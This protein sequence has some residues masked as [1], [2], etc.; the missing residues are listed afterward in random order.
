MVFGTTE[1]GLATINFYSREWYRGTTRGFEL[2][3]LDFLW[4]FILVDEWRRPRLA[5][6]RQLPFSL[7]SM[8]V[9][10]SYNAMNVALSD[11]KLF[12]LFEL[13]KALRAVMVFLAFA[14]YVKNERDLRRLVWA[15]CLAVIYEWSWTVYARLIL[16][17][18][19]SEGT[20]SH[21]NALSMYNLIAV[22]L[23][24]A[25]AL[26]DADKRLRRAC[27]VA[28]F[29]GTTS[30]LFTV[31]RAGLLSI[32]LLLIAVGMTCGSLRITLA[33]TVAAALVLVPGGVLYAKLAPAFEAR[34]A[35]E[36]GLEREFGGE[37]NEGRGSY[38]VLARMMS[39]D[40]FLGCGLNNWS[41]Y[42]SNRYG[43]MMGLQYLPYW[44]TDEVPPDGPIPANSN[45]D[46]PQAPPGHSLYAITLGETGWLGVLLF[47][48]VWLRWLWMAGS[49]FSRRS[50]AF[51]SRFGVG[52]FFS[53]A[54]AFS[55]SVVE[56]EFRQT[57]LLF[58][59]HILL[60]AL[61]AV[62]PARPSVRV[63]SP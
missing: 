7:G 16:G 4:F 62:Y 37:A 55:Q 57:P 63:G 31:S 18:A 3:W 41:Y 14:Y 34:F 11:P 52:V 9:F 25:V 35:T 10:F 54:G 61:A 48:W 40:N 17:H 45:I 32:F 23:L 38:L 5:R 42:V 27:G 24:L 49:F 60:G 2:C 20:L 15:L 46:D 44:G 22:P 21:P 8:L 28:A 6:P 19:R 12:G 53:L 30:V 1:H 47:V 26:S 33:K 59:V 29:L 58:L 51:R 43:P 36:G 39:A 50:A 13:S 56:W